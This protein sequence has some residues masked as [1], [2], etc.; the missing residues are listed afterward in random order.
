MIILFPKNYYYFALIKIFKLYINKYF[1]LI[2]TFIFI[3]IQLF[4]NLKDI[5]ILVN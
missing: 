4:Y 3:L 2:W 5:G 1:N